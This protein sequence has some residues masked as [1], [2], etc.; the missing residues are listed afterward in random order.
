MLPA[1]VQPRLLQPG[2]DCLKTGNLRTGKC[3]ALRGIRL[4]EVRENA[5]D[6]KPR[7]AAGRK[8]TAHSLVRVMGVKAN[9]AHPRIHGKVA[10]N[11]AAVRRR[12][13]GK[14]VRRLFIMHCGRNAVFHHGRCVVFINIAQNQDGS[15]YAVLTQLDR[16]PH[17]GYPE[18]SRAMALQPPDNL[19]SAVPISVSLD[20]A[21]HRLAA[22]VRTDRLVIILYR[23]QT[24]VCPNAM[25]VL[26]H[27]TLS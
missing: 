6:R 14:N 25:S 7:Q 13:F 19:G 9:A 4:R 10:L 12:P 1:Q 18:I 5:S 21:Q 11:R 2:T 23:L 27:D 22:N 20:H 26:V 3:F 15:A 16:F 17:R 8:H 24:D